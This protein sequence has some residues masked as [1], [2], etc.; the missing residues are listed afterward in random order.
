MICFLYPL[1]LSVYLLQFGAVSGTVEIRQYC[2]KFNVCIASI[3]TSRAGLRWATECRDKR[4]LGASSSGLSIN[5]TTL[6]E[7]DSANNFLFITPD[8]NEVAIEQEAAIEYHPFVFESELSAVKKIGGVPESECRLCKY[9]GSVF[10]Y[11]KVVTRFPFREFS[12]G[13][14][15]SDLDCVITG[16][17][18]VVEDDQAL[19]EG[20]VAR[21]V[22]I[23]F[24]MAYGEEGTFRDYLDGYNTD[25]PWNPSGVLDLF[26]PLLETLKVFH[27]RNI[28]HNCINASRI[29]L[30][31][32]G[33]VLKLHLIKFNT[34]F[35]T[36]GL[37]YRQKIQRDLSLEY[38]WIAPDFFRPTYQYTTKSDVYSLGWLLCQMSRTNW[39]L[40]NAT[41]LGNFM[42]IHDAEYRPGID[43]LVSLLP[44]FRQEMNE[45]TII[46]EA[47]MLYAAVAVNK[48]RHW[49]RKEM[50][51]TGPESFSFF[52]HAE[53]QDQVSVLVEDENG[54]TALDRCFV[55]ERREVFV[56][57]AEN[58]SDVLICADF[59][60]FQ[61]RCYGSN[62]TLF[63]NG[64][65]CH[66]GYV[67]RRSLGKSSRI[68]FTNW[69]NGQVKELLE[70]FY[71]R[72]PPATNP[73]LK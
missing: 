10:V 26:E 16:V 20:V 4:S 38:N 55:L 44:D 63:L 25:F 33:G 12:M 3:K 45:L 17:A 71:R 54:K 22:V 36:D 57:R 35:H 8:C 60:Y 18:F 70:K 46:S 65:G 50:L 23:G 49:D 64:F 24:L 15:V 47:K 19:G 51:R 42:N 62:H 48:A 21:G 39:I 52:V 13:E 6:K 29:V 32:T 41:L 72:V 56:V 28:S 43:F 53:A 59:T 37:V 2:S 69:T 31:S 30:R 68:S 27:E 34:A 66:T 5:Q 73:R 61:E 40:T 9:A 11:K 1:V 67:E 14:E 7:F 58:P